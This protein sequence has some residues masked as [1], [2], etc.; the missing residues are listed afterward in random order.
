MSIQAVCP[1]CDRQYILA[2]D[3]VGKTVLCKNCD[4]AFVVEAVANRRQR[5]EQ[6]PRRRKSGGVMLALLLGGGAICL[7][8]LAG[9]GVSA[10]LLMGGLFSK[11]T[12]A[13][14]EKLRANMTESEVVA[15]LGTPTTNEGGLDNNFPVGQF[16]GNLPMKQMAWINGSNRIQVIFNGQGKAWLA[17]AEFADGKGGMRVL[18]GVKNGE[19]SFFGSQIEAAK[20]SRGNATNVSVGVNNPL[21]SLKPP[22]VGQSGAGGGPSKVTSGKA[23]VIQN[24]L[25]TEQVTQ[26]IGEPPTKKLGAQKMPSGQ[27]SQETWEWDNGK[28]FLKVHFDGNLKVAA[29]EAKDLPLF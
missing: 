9:L 20:D 5:K 11:V 25:S 8:L 15:I 13:N 10:L 7:L 26:V 17:A 6:R 14:Y 4:R 2:S 22:Q 19:L 27:L 1:R 28:G 21:Q 29:K 23:F 3:M 24:G 16:F 18:H 12:E